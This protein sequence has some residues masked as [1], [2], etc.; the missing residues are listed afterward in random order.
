VRT[1][2]P[3]GESSAA[4]TLDPIERV[5]GQA[6][7]DQEFTVPTELDPDD[8]LRENAAGLSEDTLAP[9]PEP[10]DSQEYYFD[11][12]LG[13]MVPLQANEQL[14]V[15]QEPF[16]QSMANQDLTHHE[17]AMS[18]IADGELEHTV[19]IQ[20]LEGHTDTTERVLVMTYRVVRETSDG[21]KIIQLESAFEDRPRAETKEPQEEPEANE[22]QTTPDDSGGWTDD[23]GDYGDENRAPLA[24]T[25]MPIEVKQALEHSA[26]EAT[27]KPDQKLEDDETPLDE[28]AQPA[29]P[30]AQIP[31]PEVTTPVSATTANPQ[32]TEPIPVTPPSPLSGEMTAGVEINLTELSRLNTSPYETW[33][34]PG[35]GNETT[36]PLQPEL[37]TTTSGASATAVEAIAVIRPPGV[38][39]DTAAEIG[40]ASQPTAPESAHF[41]IPP[42]KEATPPTK[43]ERQ[44]HLETT[45]ASTPRLQPPEQPKPNNE[46]LPNRLQTE[47]QSTDTTSFGASEASADTEAAF[48][49]TQPTAPTQPGAGGGRA[50]TT[51][52]MN[53]HTA[54]S[55]PEASSPPSQPARQE[56]HPTTGETRAVS[57]TASVPERQH[58]VQ[59]AIETTTSASEQAATTEDQ[60]V[61]APTTAVQVAQSHTPDTP[62]LTADTPSA[63]A[64][65]AIHATQIAHESSLSNPA[66]PE[67]VETVQNLSSIDTTT[68]IAI[69][70]PSEPPVELTAEPFAESFIET[71]AIAPPHHT[72]EEITTSQTTLPDEATATTQVE[73]SKPIPAISDNL[74]TTNQANEPAMNDK[75]AT[76]E[77]APIIE[78][79]ANTPATDHSRAPTHAT[80]TLQ[81]HQPSQTDWLTELAIAPAAGDWRPAA[82]HT[83]THPVTAE[84]RNY[85]ATNFAAPAAAPV[86]TDDTDDDLMIT[87][88]TQEPARHRTGRARKTE[89]AAA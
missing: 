84:L 71:P 72:R 7:E 27:N 51:E 80:P 49:V 57:V 24:A 50:F 38:A 17:S 35:Y 40:S 55:K 21:K 2:E 33:Q 87:F 18:A 34:P 47:P 53:A 52:P 19:E 65:E 3:N 36:T 13:D 46:P 30:Q 10:L 64:T 68:P 88:E 60:H 81:R 48:P 79:A 44:P 28:L 69:K 86:V 8:P 74:T 62:A 1:G 58:L 77:T 67:Q 83:P 73:T 39:N 29:S 85:S 31:K 63:N 11:P 12:E 32:S 25:T 5:E 70:P 61:A 43:F 45:T 26:P 41:A 15:R 66:Q 78:I 6:D 20:G 9:E 14:G 59:P 54:L 75:A 37:L 82:T 56:A 22:A 76:I 89:Q 23:G 4:A 42:A 16:K